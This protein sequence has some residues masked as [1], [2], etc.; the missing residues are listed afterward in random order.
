MATL[1]QRCCSVV[2][3]DLSEEPGELHVLVPSVAALQQ[4]RTAVHVHQALVIVVVDGWAQDADAQLPR[5]GVV[6]VLQ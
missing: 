5:A 2:L 6:H 1:K 4:A 3:A